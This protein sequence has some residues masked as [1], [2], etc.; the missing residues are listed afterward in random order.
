MAD[1]DTDTGIEGG[2]GS[3]PGEDATAAADGVTAGSVHPRDA[4]GRLDPADT[5]G[6]GF[7]P[8]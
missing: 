3:P 1:T 6:T 5:L 4:T 8:R 7:V 2:R